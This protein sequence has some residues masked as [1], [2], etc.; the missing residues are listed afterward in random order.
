MSQD[1][2]DELFAD[3]NHTEL[4][5]VCRR[6]GMKVSPSEPKENL[7]DY[8]VGNR[9]PPNSPN[10]V[11]TWR[12]GIMGFLL[13]HWQTVRSQLSCPA[14]SGEPDA[15]FGCTDSQVIS[16]VASNPENEDLIQLKRKE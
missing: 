5:Q 9:E 12:H 16:C 4:Y 13:D 14:K 2:A 7:I 6:M 10:V 15:C 8:L 11:D 1:S 3:C